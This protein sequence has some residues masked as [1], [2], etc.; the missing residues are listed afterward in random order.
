MTTFDTLNDERR[1]FPAPAGD[2][3]IGPAEHAA[4]LAAGV[5]RESRAGAL[6][7]LS[8]AMSWGPAPWAGLVF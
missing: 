6:R 1:R 5:V 7:E 3:Q 4:L 2:W 8:T